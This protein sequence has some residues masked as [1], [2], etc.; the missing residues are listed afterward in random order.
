M[1]IAILGHELAVAVHLL[2]VDSGKSSCHDLSY[3][4]FHI[5]YTSFCS[6]LCDI[7]LILDDLTGT[8]E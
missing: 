7:A 6:L 2:L 1:K 5:S 4:K 3:H 8:E